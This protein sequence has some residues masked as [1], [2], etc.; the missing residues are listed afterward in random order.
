MP[1]HSEPI[2]WQLA[3]RLATKLA[4]GESLT[5]LLAALSASQEN[6]PLWQV[7]GLNQDSDKLR[8]QLCLWP[9]EAALQMAAWR[10][11]SQPRI[12]SYRLTPRARRVQIEKI[13]L[14]EVQD[15]ASRE[16]QRVNALA[17]SLAHLP[18]Y[19]ASEIAQ[20]A[21]ECGQTSPERVWARVDFEDIPLLLG[22]DADG[23]P[24]VRFPAA[25]PAG[26]RGRAD[27]HVQCASTDWREERTLGAAARPYNWIVPVARVDEASNVRWGLIDLEGR[28]VLPCEYGYLSR[29]EGWL[30]GE[31]PKLPEGRREPWL[32][33]MARREPLVLPEDAQDG[34]D[35]PLTAAGCDVIEVWSGAQV[36]PP[37]YKALAETLE[38]GKFLVRGTDDHTDEPRLGRM[39]AGQ[40]GP[41]PLAW[42]WI[43]HGLTGVDDRIPAEDAETGLYA[44]IDSK[45]DTA[46]SP[47][48]SDARR[49][50]SGIAEVR[51][52]EEAAQAE[53]ILLSVDNHPYAPWGVINEMGDWVLAPR[54]REIEDEYDGHFM[55]Q[56]E[57]GSW[58]VV[59]PAGET[60]VPFLQ[61]I[62]TG[63]IGEWLKERFKREQARRFHR[64]MRTASTEGCLAVL[65]GKLHSSYGRYDYGALPISEETIRIIRPVTVTGQYY[66]A[67]DSGPRDVLLEPGMYGRWKPGARHYAHFVDLSTHAVVEIDDLKVPWDALA[68]TPAPPAEFDAPAMA[69]RFARL[70]S[71]E[72][73][74]ALMAL[75][76]AMEEESE[77]L[78][79]SRLA[80]Q[81]KK[82]PEPSDPEKPWSGRFSDLASV[83]NLSSDYSSLN[84]HP[85]NLYFLESCLNRNDAHMFCRT[86]ERL[87]QA[88]PPAASAA[89]KAARDVW[90]KCFK[91]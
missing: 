71:T 76:E 35:L 79:S 45:G 74:E 8:R 47:R 65:A 56:A 17:E 13:T 28:F 39:Q 70:N 89:I 58:G 41:G 57:D 15:L 72:H 36:N 5:G 51:L 91:S 12:G 60:V 55:V 6:H 27:W 69:A 25:W 38:C 80:A 16:P 9:D 46:L 73:R 64:W 86:I 22:R 43:A 21:K 4:D 42:R 24:R 66:A 7:T 40:P 1:I 54:W 90:L 31:P 52:T 78:Y 88:I 48:Y 50:N 77:R 61:T 68:L 20:A 10:E 75:I 18:P 11:L 67:Q 59:T 23:T 3:L 62:I 14:T 2:S 81:E 84:D 49:F 83:E 26:P 30:G 19:T 32:W 53:G 33:V 37:R 29:P 34:A 82:Q 44:Y 85:L 63:A 87:E